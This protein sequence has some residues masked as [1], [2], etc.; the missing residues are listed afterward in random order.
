MQPNF[1]LSYSRKYYLWAVGSG[2]LS[3]WK[4][5]EPPKPLFLNLRSI[6]EGRFF[7]REVKV[8]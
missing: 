1:D 8:V 4:L 3:A 6:K 2:L 5:I 7:S